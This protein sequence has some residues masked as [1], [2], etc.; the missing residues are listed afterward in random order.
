M[1]VYSD[2]T[3]SETVNLFDIMKQICLDF[4]GVIHSYTSRWVGPT[5]IPDP[6]V[7]GAI[8]FIHNCMDNGLGVMIYSTRNSSPGAIQSMLDWLNIHGL[9]Y[10]YREKI[11]FPT[12][13]PIMASLF[14][15][16]RGFQFNG[17]WP[18]VQYMKEFQPYY[19]R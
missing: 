16:D 13:K 19:K 12:D 5:H 1:E 2:Y 3:G 17:V 18:S 6:P 15:D 11:Q 14:I 7:E 10:H 9:K 4:D 8:Q